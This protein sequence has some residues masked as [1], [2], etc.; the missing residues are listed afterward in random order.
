MRVCVCVRENLGRMRA[1]VCVR[2][3]LGRVCVCVCVCVARVCAG[4]SF[5]FCSV[6]PPIRW[7]G[8]RFFL[9]KKFKACLKKKVKSSFY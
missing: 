4:L 8:T 6:M 2:E 5:A 3:N 7:I 9:I 1:R